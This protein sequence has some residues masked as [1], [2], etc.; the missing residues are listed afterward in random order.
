MKG[1]C[2]SMCWKTLIGSPVRVGNLSRY[3]SSNMQL[4]WDPIATKPFTEIMIGTRWA[5]NATFRQDTLRIVSVARS[6]RTWELR[7]VLWT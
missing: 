4:I 6:G 7:D 5:V 2:P 1:Q 3:G